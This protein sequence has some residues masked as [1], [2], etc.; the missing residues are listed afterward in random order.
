MRKGLLMTGRDMT[1]LKHLSVGPT[2]R[3]SIFSNIFEVKESNKKTRERVMLRRLAKHELEGLIKSATCPNV[4]DTIY[5]LTKKAAPIVASHYG[6]ELSNIWVNYSEKTIEHDLYTSGCAKKII[7]EAEEKKMFKLNALVLEC[8]LKNGKLKKGVYFPDILFGIDG[9]GRLNIFY[10]EMDCGTVCR[11]DFIG[12]INYFKDRVL[13]ITK[14]LARI[15]LLM[16]YLRAEKISG[17]VFFSTYKNFSDNS[18]LT[19]TW[20]SNSSKEPTVIKIY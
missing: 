19:C 9:P 14:T 6:M 13:V 16:W 7:K 12:K 11:R 8:G 3:K 4:K 17:P 18:F 1:L 15:D 10:L 5:F 2:T 20:Y